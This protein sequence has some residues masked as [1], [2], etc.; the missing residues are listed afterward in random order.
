M[1]GGTVIYV[2]QRLPTPHA[3]LRGLVRMDL[4]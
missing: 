2:S 4:A 3:G 1:K